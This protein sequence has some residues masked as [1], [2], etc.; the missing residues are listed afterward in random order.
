MFFL[1]FSAYTFEAFKTE[2]K[3]IA[4]LRGEIFFVE[5]IVS[6]NNRW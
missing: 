1:L 4:V 3:K 2:Q 5:S 6:P